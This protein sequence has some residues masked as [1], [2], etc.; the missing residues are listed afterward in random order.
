MVWWFDGLMVWW[1]DGLMVWWF[2]GIELHL[3]NWFTN[4]IQWRILPLYRSRHWRIFF[5]THDF[6]TED[7]WENCFVS[8][9]IPS[10][11]MWCGLKTSQISWSVIYV[12]ICRGTLAYERLI[13]VERRLERGFYL[14]LRNLVSCY[15]LKKWSLM[16]KI[17]F[18]F[19]LNK[20][21]K[22]I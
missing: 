22:H 3:F 19:L 9:T 10:K 4:L 8:I 5:I 15:S 7:A 6:I 1:F 2:D 12:Y 20:E 11:Q 14:G 21:L 17:Q 13:G 18:N 16:N